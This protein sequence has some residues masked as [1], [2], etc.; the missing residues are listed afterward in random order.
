MCTKHMTVGLYLSMSAC[1]LPWTIVSINECIYMERVLL[2][3]LLEPV[4]IHTLQYFRHDDRSKFWDVSFNQESRNS[5][6]SRMR[7]D[8]YFLRDV[9][10]TQSSEILCDRACVKMFT[11][12]ETWASLRAPKFDVI[13]HAWRYLLPSRRELHSEPRNSM[14]SHMREDVY[15]LCD[16]VNFKLSRS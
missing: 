12:F 11:S 3:Y 5:V 1:P 8:V 2:P 7:E 9:S 15:F 13:A 16:V 4:H 6:W 14:W 10:F